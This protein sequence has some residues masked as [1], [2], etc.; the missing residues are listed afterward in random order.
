MTAV[1]DD[2]DLFAVIWTR[3]DQ[4]K[5]P[6][7]VYTG[8]IIFSVGQVLMFSNNAATLFQLSPQ[9]VPPRVV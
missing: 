3:F 6:A 8:A 1:S 7:Q 9:P 5:A 2:K 4:T